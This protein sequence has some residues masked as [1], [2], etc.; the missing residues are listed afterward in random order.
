MLRKLHVARLACSRMME[1]V[2]VDPYGFSSC[3]VLL[4]LM[5]AQATTG[6]MSTIPLSEIH[7]LNDNTFYSFYNRPT[8]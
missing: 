4:M 8:T 6:I 3:G 1:S 2:G 7:H 5:Q